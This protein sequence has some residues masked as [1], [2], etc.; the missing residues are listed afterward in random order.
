MI[1]FAIGTSQYI[2]N[3]GLLKKSIK[4]K[5]FLQ[6]IQKKIK[7]VNLIDTAPS[8]NNVEKIIG[9]YSNKNLKIITKFNKT[10][11]KEINKKF[12]EIKEGFLESLINLDKKRIYAVLFHHREDIKILKNIA[13][14]KKFNLL[15]KNLKLKVGF[16]SYDINNIEKFLK[17]YKF[18]IIQIPLNPFNINKKKILFLKKLKKKYKLEIHVRSIFLQGLGL[19][20]ISF[21][22]KKFNLLKKRIIKIDNVA[23]KYKISRYDFYISLIQSLNIVDYVII[24]MASKKDLN[25]IKNINFV[26]INNKDIYNFEIKNKRLIDPRFWD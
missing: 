17:I 16:S 5:N 10:N 12:E 8:Y 20:K 22:S 26:K 1:K 13:I 18:D 6:I 3:Y 9:N 7:N 24:G 4:K 21:F 25:S 11:S 23:E 15:R 14:K 19:Q 2:K